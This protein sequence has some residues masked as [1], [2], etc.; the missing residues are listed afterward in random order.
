MTINFYCALVKLFFGQENLL[1]NSC[2]KI[3]EV[4]TNFLWEK[5][6]DNIIY[7]NP[8]FVTPIG[9]NVKQPKVKHC[10]QCILCVKTSK[11]INISLVK[12]C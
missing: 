1:V 6:H 5:N 10:A 9:S 4:I 8:C 7:V 3:R 2:L 12:S 11:V